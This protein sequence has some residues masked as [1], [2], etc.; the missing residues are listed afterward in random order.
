M[1]SCMSLRDHASPS[2]AL[3]SC[4][5]LP[6]G[7][8]VTWGVTPAL[9]LVINVSVSTMLGE[10]PVSLEESVGGLAALRIPFRSSCNAMVR[11]V[12]MVSSMPIVPTIGY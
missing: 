6:T 10:A 4:R 2:D 3:V 7:I 1:T 12:C 11:N 5:N 9:I 8:N